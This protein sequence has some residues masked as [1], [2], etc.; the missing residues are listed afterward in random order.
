MSG[1]DKK[2][3]LDEMDR[4]VRRAR[5]QCDDFGTGYLIGMAVTARDFAM[6]RMQRVEGNAEEKAA[7]LGERRR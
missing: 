1:S 4:I 7:T 2:E 5:R 6:T 3:R